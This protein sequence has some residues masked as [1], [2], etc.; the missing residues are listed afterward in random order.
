MAK[1]GKRWRDAKKGVSGVRRAAAAFAR[2]KQA[3]EAGETY[4]SQA[5]SQYRR[6]SRRA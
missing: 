2:N 3:I 5:P 1:G 6:R 4:R